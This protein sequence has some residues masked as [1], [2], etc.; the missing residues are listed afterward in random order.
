[1]MDTVKV[2]ADSGSETDLVH[3]NIEEEI[4]DVK[5]EAFS[6]PEFEVS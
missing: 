5:K 2:E 4:L 3:V 6:D 1:M